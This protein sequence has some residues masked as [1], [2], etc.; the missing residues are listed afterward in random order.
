MFSFKT[1]LNI[2]SISWYSIFLYEY[3]HKIYS[4]I[5]EKILKYNECLNTTQIYN[6]DSINTEILKPDKCIY[7][8]ETIDYY[9]DLISL[10]KKPYQNR[11]YELSNSNNH[12]YALAYMENYDTVK[13]FIYIN[14]KKDKDIFCKYKSH[15]P[16]KIVANLVENNRRYY[17]IQNYGNSYFLDPSFELI[18]LLTVELPN[19]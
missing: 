18:K 10:P 5:N 12:H 11:L 7:K 6:Q 19:C 16:S 4:N 14:F 8:K 13:Y 2:L 17:A 9:K 15:I 1:L 3:L